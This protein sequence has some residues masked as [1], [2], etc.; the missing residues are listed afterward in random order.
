MADPDH[1]YELSERIHSNIDH[2]KK[3]AAFHALQEHIDAA[4]YV[5]EADSITSA[6]K[7]A[8]R[9]SNQALSSAAL[10]FL[11]VY[12]SLL[13]P[14]SPNLEH[15][16]PQ[17]VVNHNVRLLVSSVTPSVIEKLGDQKERIREAARNA[18]VELGRAAYGVSGAQLASS[19]K[20]KEVESALGIFERLLREGGL[21]AKF[22]R[23]RE[24][25][26]QVL[27]PLR[28][29]CERYPVRPL[30]PYMVDLLADADPSVREAS[31]TTI[32]A[33]FIN[34]TS[35]AKSELKKELEKK[36]VRKQ[37][38]DAVLREVLAGGGPPASLPSAAADPPTPKPMGFMPVDR[39][40]ASSNGASALR[41]S[42]G[43]GGH[44]PSA[45]VDGSA[46][47]ASA[48]TSTPSSLW[49]RGA[50]PASDDIKTVY[51]ASRSDLERT[52]QSFLPFF[53][54]KETEHNWLQREQS[55]IKMRG[56]IKAGIPRQFGEAHFVTCVRLLQEGILK[57]LASLRT[58]LSMHAAGLLAELAV[59]LGD[60][61]A[62]CVES[63]LTAL[64]RMAGFT[65][66]IIANATQEAAAAILV[67]VSYRHLYLQQIWHGLQEK[68][69]ATR[70]AGADHLV[71]VLAAHV[72]Q[73]KHSIESHGGLD[74][75]DK[76]FRRGLC[77]QNPE[78]RSKSREAFWK[79]FA[80]W[81][82][83]AKSLLNALDTTAKKQV[84]ASAPP[85]LDLEAAIEVKPKG[86][87][88]PTRRPGGPSS[89]I[90]AAKRAASAKA[91]QE[92]ERQM[93]EEAAAAHEARL[94]AAAAASALPATSEATRQP[95][96]QRIAVPLEGTPRARRVVSG[97]SRST[98][99]SHQPNGIAMSPSGS[100]VR[101]EAAQVPLPTSPPGSS[102][103]TPRPRTISIVS[104]PSSNGSSSGP[105]SPT[106][107]VSPRA[108]ASLQSLRQRAISTSSNGSGPAQMTPSASSNGS[109][110]R[111][112]MQPSEEE[113]D[114]DLDDSRDSVGAD[115][116]D[117][118]DEGDVTQR[119]ASGGGDEDETMQLPA[120]A[121]VSVDLMNFDSPFK[122]PGR[123]LP[124]QGTGTAGAY[125]LGD[126][127]MA[128]MDTPMARPASRRP[129]PS[130]PQGPP[131]RSVSAT[132]LPLEPHSPTVSS[133]PSTPGTAKRRSGLPRP[134][135]MFHRGPSPL[136]NRTSSQDQQASSS[137]AGDSVD[138][139][140]RQHRASKSVDMLAASPAAAAPV[141]P[142]SKE[143]RPLGPAE[144]VTAP[145]T[146][147]T[148]RPHKWF[149]SRAA[150]LES[151]ATTMSPAKSKPESA[152]WI[153]ALASGQADRR[154]FQRLLRLSSDFKV[155]RRAVSSAEAAEDEPV[156]R[157]GRLPASSSAGGG[158]AQGLAKMGEAEESVHGS[159]S[160]GGRAA[161]RSGSDTD[162]AVELWQ[163]NEL[164]TRLLS[165]L[166]A[167][168]LSTPASELQVAGL[169]VLHR[170]IENQQPLFV[171]C[172]KETEL[173]DLCFTLRQRNAKPNWKGM[174]ACLAVLSA[175][176]SSTDPLLGYSA[177]ASCTAHHLTSSSSPSSSA[178]S[179]ARPSAEEGVYILGLSTLKTLTERLPAELIEDMLPTVASLLHDAIHHADP[180]VRQAAVE[181]LTAANRQLKGEYAVIFDILAKAGEVQRDKMDLLVY[182]FHKNAALST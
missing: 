72:P 24:Q 101:A 107:Y 97:L 35:G 156:L 85:G 130:Q 96:S 147:T 159:S 95:P 25:A 122:L 116:D 50:L 109:G 125:G 76:C 19:G 70:I 49:S 11:S 91:A 46:A 169:V 128:F 98:N 1:I 126:D 143:N 38:L 73:R 67:H 112:H 155:P 151:A 14:V 163:D 62:P 118:D 34:A 171:A 146:T 106:A 175:W 182:Y 139:V 180:G 18:L 103:S 157:P 140:H 137:E 111:R 127:S 32:V 94:A 136:S 22:A 99:L 12:I 170:L 3:V 90:L 100:L 161:A 82:A 108:P 39:S 4:G 174:T 87:G 65:K 58:T 168:V 119:I 16:E 21:A 144:T 121:D 123:S 61:L 104:Q 110:Q 165:A 129:A 113:E 92:R 29:L 153:A 145:E 51:V 117:D 124:G 36:G 131:S 160:S 75:L 52:F 33:L 27:G 47:S 178:S 152:E 88:I 132:Q 30:L 176:A 179:T 181:V 77:D 115:V 60:D 102:A 40:G 120:P 71:V 84:M 6:V 45:A 164:F 13:Y 7:V 56:M 66:K 89:A 148:D 42:R 114:E 69:V 23:V 55:T 41:S 28:Q 44:P 166:F 8:M 86:S 133:S 5:V 81:N 9:S 149:L 141:S 74:I 173:L 80:V 43:Q 134:A 142:S 172:S 26:V 167:F 150:R 20:G 10:L 93:A 59:A 154:I 37:V 63:F 68:N 31:R 53:E 177:T 17:N 2:D 57:S 138:T 158:G 83:E 135:S 162:L 78:V 54:G 15:P 64:M 79:F 105:R 48:S